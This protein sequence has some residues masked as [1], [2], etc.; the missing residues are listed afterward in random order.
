MGRECMTI[1]LRGVGICGEGNEG[2]GFREDLFCVQL[3]RVLM[4]MT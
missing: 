2:N 3:A 4:M 1:P